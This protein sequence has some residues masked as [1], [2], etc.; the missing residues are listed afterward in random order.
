MKTLSTTNRK[1]GKCVKMPPKIAYSS[2]KRG[3]SRDSQRS[4]PRV[5]MRAWLEHL[6]DEGLCRGLQWVD[7]HSHQF[8]VVWRHG[9][10]SGFNPSEHSEVFSRWAQHTG[11]LE[12]GN[13]L[14]NSANKSAFRCALHSLKDCIDITKEGEIKG[15]SAKRTFQFINPGHP[16]Y[17]RKKRSRCSK[18]KIEP[19]EET[20][21]F[22]SDT[23]EQDTQTPDTEHIV[24]DQ[25][26]WTPVTG[27]IV[28]DQDTNTWESQ[29]TMETHDI[30]QETIM[31]PYPQA[32]ADAS[33]S[34]AYPSFIFQAT[35]IPVDVSAQETVVDTSSPIADTKSLGFVDVI[36]RTVLVHNF[37]GLSLADPTNTTQ[38]LFETQPNEIIVL[39]LNGEVTQADNADDSKLPVFSKL[40]VSDTYE[41]PF[42]H[43]GLNS[44]GSVTVKKGRQM[45]SSAHHFLIK[46]PSVEPQDQ[47]AVA[48][49]PDPVDTSSDETGYGTSYGND[50]MDVIEGMDINNP[51]EIE[52]FGNA[53]AGILTDLQHSPLADEIN[54]DLANFVLGEMDENDENE[55]LFP[56]KASEHS[57]EEKTDEI[58]SSNPVFILQR[59]FNQ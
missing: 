26:A 45:N 2:K 41:V 58:S 15:E 48:T 42:A 24:T 31:W 6:L 23:D 19:K 3:N 29:P 59:I 22:T 57:L 34:R 20:A 36:E 54:V 17:D 37:D 39:K 40:G 38:H 30:Q 25:D 21:A 27:H 56:E 32:E 1:G 28:N 35:E 52:N 53:L 47:S 4:Q 12:R 13:G 14:D 7:K 44:G 46:Q 43:T 8:S 10:S 11:K 33:T 16:K 9:S 5:L 55:I 50:S 49:V 18:K 51:G